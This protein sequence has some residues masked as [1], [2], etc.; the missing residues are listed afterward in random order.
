MASPA[1]RMRLSTQRA[2]ISGNRQ[3]VTIATPSQNALRTSTNGGNRAGSA[4]AQSTT[5]DIVTGEPL[6]QNAAKPR[7]QSFSQSQNTLK[8]STSRGSLLPQPTQ[9]VSTVT[10][11]KYQEDMLAHQTRINKLE[12]ELR[13]LESEKAMIGLQHEKELREAQARADADYKKYQEA[14]SERLKAVRASESAA[15]QVRDVRDRGVNDS[16]T[17]ERKAREL[18]AQCEMLKEEKEDLEAQLS[19][20]HRGQKL[21]V[22][23]VEALRK[24]LESTTQEAAAEVEEMKQR[25]DVINKQLIEQKLYAEEQEKR[26]LELNGK[27]GG[28]DELEVLKREFHDQ[29]ATTKRLEG[30]ERDQRTKIKKFEDERR[31]VNVVLEEKRTLE[32]QIEVLKEA[33]RRAGEL[34]IQKEILEDEKRTWTTLLSKEG[35]EGQNEFD[36]PEA[37]VRAL[38][39]ERIN[40]ALV[41]ERL[42]MVE[43]ELMGKDEAL[44]AVESERTVL[45]HKVRELSERIDKEDAPAP[46]PETKQIAR[47]QRQ[48]Q[49]AQKEIAYLRA[50]L[51]T[52]T[53][54]QDMDEN[55]GQDTTHSLQL[56]KLD[57]LLNEHKAEINNLNARIQMIE[58]TPP[59]VVP[60]QVVGQKR[61]AEDDLKSEQQGRLERKNKDLQVAL[62]KTM[63]QSQMMAK[64]FQAVKSQLKALRASRE[65]RVLELRD[66]PTAQHEALKASTI[67]I[68]KQEALDLRA[69]LAGGNAMK[70]VRVVPVSSLEA[71]KLDLKDMER[72]LADKEKRMKRQK[73]IWHEKAAEFRDVISSVLG[74]KVTFLPNGKVKV[75]SVYYSPRRDEEEEEV[76]EDDRED[77]IEFDGER[78]T[79]K[80][81]GGRDG[82]FGQEMATDI[83]YWVAEKKEIPVFLAATTMG[84]YERYHGSGD[85]T[86]S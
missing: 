2:S 46:E 44:S 84:F 6:E 52:Y 58:A 39:N 32:V 3:N 5:Y 65:Q 81:G 56:A 45:N 14:E 49:L 55:A 70:N 35:E 61:P 79:M 60:A 23:E 4:L 10:Q 83:N 18:N 48:Q 34:E 33:E 29:L 57:N 24:K 59:A 77:Y 9:P 19:D 69:Q 30:I 64:E 73:E 82:A 71:L 76:E 7:R 42:G 25:F 27:G 11:A 41:L 37:V 15:K 1:K 13:N 63:A 68:L 38:V 74:Y 26:V 78:G 31:S 40:H 16:A 66:N 72:A 17:I 36:T 20:L 51:E 50:Q 75:R 62:Q 54:E 80:I 22:D 53:T 85:E 86:I 28:S 67:R 43:T 8:R 47:L 21:Q 12:Y